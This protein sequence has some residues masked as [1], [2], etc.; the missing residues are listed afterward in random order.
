[1]AK[2]YTSDEILKM[3]VGLIPEDMDADLDFD[4]KIT[5]SDARFSDRK[6][7]GLLPADNISLMAENVVNRIIRDTDAYSYDVSTDPLYGKYRNMYR[8]AGE[9]SAEDLMGKA[10]A[11]TGGYGNSYAS[12]I[13]ASEKE[14]YNDL[15]LSKA[16]ELEEKAY[17]RYSSQLD[18][19]YALYN[20][21]SDEDKRQ[22]DKEKAALDFAVTASGL[23]DNSF[24]EALG[25]DP[26]DEDFRKLKE[27]AEFFADYGDYSLLEGLGVNVSALSEAEQREIAE[28][29]AKYGDYSLLKKLGVN[30][31]DRETEEYYDRLIKR[32]KT[33]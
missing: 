6:E 12:K 15:T 9:L 24:I 1:M 17:K 32:M 19:L 2:K 3:A 5:S 11:L 29:Y 28:F 33:W 18:S 7:S 23:G 16:E 13:A 14:K 27:K 4:G 22:E 20:L 21:L 25:I 8:Q 30:T 10:S 31:S 26:G